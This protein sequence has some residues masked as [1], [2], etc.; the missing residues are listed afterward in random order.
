MGG[1]I[2]Y[3]FRISRK[4]SARTFISSLCERHPSENSTHDCLL[5]RGLH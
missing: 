3:N 4:L 5:L 2:N 1:E